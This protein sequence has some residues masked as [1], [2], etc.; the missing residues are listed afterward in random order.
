MAPEIVFVDPVILVINAVNHVILVFGERSVA[1]D[2]SAKIPK[3]HATMNQG[4]ANVCRVGEVTNAI[5][6]VN[7]VIMA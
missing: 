6:H 3:E 4:S 2:A 5:F 1:K 7:L